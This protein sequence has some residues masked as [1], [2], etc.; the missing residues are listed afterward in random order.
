MG[1]N[2]Y[3]E[4]LELARCLNFTKAAA[5]LHVTQPALSKHI[6]A[7]E[8][9]FGTTFFERDRRSVQL[10]DAG[11]VMVECATAMVDAYD[12]AVDAL[13]E[14]AA[15]QPVRVDGVLFDGTVSGIISLTS[16]LLN[17]KGLPPLSATHHEGKSPLELLVN[18]TIDLALSGVDDETAAQN[19]LASRPLLEIPFAAILDHDHPLAGRSSLRMEELRDE[20]FVHFID[21]YATAAWKDIETVCRN[22][23]FEPRTRPVLGSAATYATIRPDGAVLIQQANLRQLKFIEEIG[24]IAVVPISDEDAHF[25][26]DL[27]YHADDERR[28]APVLEVFE[29]ARAIALRRGRFAGQ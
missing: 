15:K 2:E 16:M 26:I 13:A 6:S 27:V 29:E 8:K 19:G 24:D 21:E 7:L 23:G 10:T 20:T 11:R 28:L 1:V 5:T 14:L 12:S 18:R 9:E 17:R 22:H 25:T 3:R 4:F